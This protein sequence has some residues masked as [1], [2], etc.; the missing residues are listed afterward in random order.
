[1][2]LSNELFRESALEQLQSP[3]QLDK[4]LRVTSPRGWVALTAIWLLLAVVIAWAFLG[5]IPTKELGGGMIVPGGGLQVVDSTGS[6]RIALEDIPVGTRIAAGQVVARIGKK[7]LID[8]LEQAQSQL[9]EL[10]H[11]N[12]ELDRLDARETELRLQLAAEEK[13]RIEESIVIARNRIGRLEEKQPMILGLIEQGVM[14]EVDRH[15]IE[16]AIELTKLEV[17]QGRLK[18]DQV[19]ERLAQ[20]TFARDRERTKRGLKKDELSGRVDLLSSRYE[21]ESTVRSPVSG[22]VVEIRIA[23]QTAISAG[24]PILLVEPAG[25]AATE[26]EAVIFVSAATAKGRIKPGDPVAL[27]PSTVKQEEFGFLRGTVTWIAEVPTSK[28]RMLAVVADH[29]L[30]EEF[31]REIGLPL[32]MHVALNKSEATPSGYEWSSKDGPPSRI[33]AGTLCGAQVTVEEQMPISFVIPQLRR[34][35]VGD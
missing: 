18:L 9:A 26:L 2:P 24:D 14:T 21:R 22:R 28:S 31:T 20:A 35:P 3:E 8:Q 7:D 17:Q 25:T 19:D 16:E 30:V 11:Q 13:R 5:T 1:M 29:D 34:K 15:E 12:Q 27:T 10:E 23:D 6:G 4:L 32:E 33:S